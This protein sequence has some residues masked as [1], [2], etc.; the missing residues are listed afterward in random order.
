MEQLHNALINLDAGESV[1][2][3]I[4]ETRRV[5]YFDEKEKQYFVEEG[6]TRKA[7]GTGDIASDYAWGIKYLPDSGVLNPT[8]YR[9]LAKRILANETRRDLEKIHNYELSKYE[10]FTFI[11]FRERFINAKEGEKAS[12]LSETGLIAEIVV[13]ELLSRIG[14]NNNLNFVVSRATIK[15]DQDFK[16]DFK[17]RVRHRIRGVDIDSKL[18][19]KY[20]GFDL[21]TQFDRKSVYLGQT[22]KGVRKQVDEIFILKVPGKD[23]ANAFHQWFRAGEPSGGPEQFLSPELKK[24]I[25]KAVTEKLVD[26]PQEIF[27]K[28]E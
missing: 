27:D 4:D 10:G 12:L 17:I 18:S 20:L 9:T 8:A 1:E 22:K 7:I 19:N 6:G 21:K 25:L 11:K 24:A 26:I 14:Q 23:I 3:F 13:R 15:E 16:Y 28:I 5:V 2:K